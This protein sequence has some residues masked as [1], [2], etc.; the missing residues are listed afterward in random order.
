MATRSRSSASI[1][2]A[3]TR[4]VTS[5]VSYSASRWPG[6]LTE[7]PALVTMRASTS[8]MS[9]DDTRSAVVDCRS[10]SWASSASTWLASAAACRRRR[11]PRRPV[12]D[13]LAL[14]R[15]EHLALRMLDGE[16]RHAEQDTDR[17]HEADVELAVGAVGAL[18]VVQPVADDREVLADVLHVH[19]GDGGELRRGLRDV[20]EHH[21]RRS[22]PAQED[23]DAGADRV[24][25]RGLADVD[26]DV[27]VVE[28]DRRRLEERDLLLVGAPVL[29]VL[30][31][32][33]AVGRRRRARRHARRPR[34]P[35][36]GGRSGRSD[37]SWSLRSHTPGLTEPCSEISARM[38]AQS[39]RRSPGSVLG[40]SGW[41]RR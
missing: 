24:V 37:R 3:C 6:A 9:S 26:R 25:E 40:V 39:R 41:R 16:R 27:G 33:R 5:T 12:D 11:R 18:G 21:A 20:G 4:A 17:A 31:H 2:S 19:V 35:R 34:R 7:R 14:G 23:A 32:R 30:E 13:V 36:G 38:D 29:L 1:P 28:D 10:A 15:A 8:S 22:E